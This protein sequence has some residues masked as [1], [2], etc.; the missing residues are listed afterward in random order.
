[1]MRK[2]ILLSLAVTFISS[3]IIGAEIDKNK[4]VERIQKQQSEKT[5][6]SKK[7]NLK[8]TDLSRKNID[9]YRDAVIANYYV[10]HNKK[11]ADNES[12]VRM[13]LLNDNERE[14][15]NEIEKQQKLA[16]QQKMDE[17]KKEEQGFYTR[18]YCSFLNQV[19]VSDMVAFAEVECM[20]DGI[21]YSR[22]SIALHPEH[23]SKALVGQALTITPDGTEQRD[24]LEVRK[25]VILNGLRTG[26][27][28]AS[29]VNDRKIEKMA[30]A[31]MLATNYIV[32]DESIKYMDALIASRKNESSQV[33]PGTGGSAPIVV[34]NSNTEKPVVSDSVALAG[35]RL[36]SSL[37][38]IVGE[39]IINNL[40]Y[41]Y[42]IEKGQRIYFDGV[43]ARA[44]MK[45]KGGIIDFTNKTVVHKSIQNVSVGNT[46]IVTYENANKAEDDTK[47]LQ[48]KH[49]DT[50]GVQ[51]TTTRRRR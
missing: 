23:S 12:G 50:D 25:G 15:R 32:S 26:L 9:D 7:V 10:E 3:S 5:A 44:D 29:I 45:G 2:K 17:Q 48:I 18:G 40:P 33:I 35:I 47:D 27:N 43:V 34:Q 6:I 51:D 28:I 36:A 39:S 41:L 24:R 13:A 31:G 30:A 14:L 21:G 49:S 20:L 1:M 8:D 38:G 37:V 22:M 11:T 16:A 46:G 19:D 4:I 42:R